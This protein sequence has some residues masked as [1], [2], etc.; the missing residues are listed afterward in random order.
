MKSA[1][2]RG[3]NFGLTSGVITTLGL[4]VGL[5][6]ATES[7]LAVIGGIITIAVADALSDALGIH[8]SEEGEKE[9]SQKHVWQATL[10]TAAY[11]F[12]IA[13]TFLI[14]ILIF[15]LGIAMITSAIWGLL[16]LGFVSKKI[17]EQ[18]EMKLWKVLLEH[19][20]IAIA[21]II[22]TLY[23]GIWINSAFI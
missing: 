2:K 15:N 11:K 8:I 10:S 13:L 17:A 6:F 7:R 22:I 1:I 19:Y 14:P 20:I 3:F 4:I 9:N 16:I 21:V 23:L 18:R 12:V 5:T